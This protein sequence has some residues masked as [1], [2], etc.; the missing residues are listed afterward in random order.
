MHLQM[1]VTKIINKKDWRGSEGRN[2]I[3]RLRGRCGGGLEKKKVKKERN[4]F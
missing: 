4:I 2:N 3:R 1:Y